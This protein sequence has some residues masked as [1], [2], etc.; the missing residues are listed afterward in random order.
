MLA[1]DKWPREAFPRQPLRWVFRPEFFP[2][3]GSSLRKIRNPIRRFVSPGLRQPGASELIQLQVVEA[4]RGAIHKSQRLRGFPH[5]RALRNRT[6]ESLLHRRYRSG[7]DAIRTTAEAARR[8]GKKSLLEARQSRLGTQCLLLGARS[9][10]TTEA[11]NSRE[12]AGG[13]AAKASC[14][15]PA[16]PVDPLFPPVDPPF[17]PVD[18]PFPPCAPHSSGSARGRISASWRRP[19]LPASTS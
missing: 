6:G 18:P 19:E 8:V 2:I 10:V 15:P 9:G 17:P 1:D 7:P 11:K 14:G 13:I 3:D 12:Q 5:V 16:P 4:I